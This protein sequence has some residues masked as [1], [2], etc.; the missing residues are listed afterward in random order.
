MSEARAAGTLYD[1]GYQRYEGKRL[2]RNHA[3]ANL[4]GY[5]VRSAFGIGRGAKAKLIPMFLTAIVFIPAIIQ[6]SGA[7]ALNQPEMVNYPFQ[8]NVSAF[9]IALFVAV[10]AP[11]LIVTDKQQGVLSLYLSR[12]L[13][14]RD[15]ALSKMFALTGALMV[16]TFGPQF[17]LFLG[18]V[19]VSPTPWTLL[20]TEYKVL[21]P[22][23]GGAMMTALFIGGIGLGVASLTAKR[24]HG[25]AAVIGVF[26]IFPAMT[27]L[28]RSIA[29]GSVRKYAKLADPIVVINGFTTWLF[30]VQA[31]R[32]SL[33][34]RLDLPGQAYLYLMIVVTVLAGI[35]LVW[36][37]RRHY[38]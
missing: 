29:T 4:M 14:A 38:A 28:V 6:V 16:L 5:S 30:D 11:E 34:S 31:S 19:L 33:I 15:Y 36:R 1:L 23:V 10:Q 18:K 26:L 2:G 32:R 22:I 20:K 37:Y 3:I 17:L 27:S 12:P 25:T 24:A 8:L 13:T 21:A 35:L 9:L 7:A